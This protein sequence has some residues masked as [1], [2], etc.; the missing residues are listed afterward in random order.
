MTGRPVVTLAC[1]AFLLAACAENGAGEPG[2]G[3]GVTP[4]TPAD[5]SAGATASQ[6]PEVQAVVDAAVADL[7]RR[8]GAG[9]EPI[10]VLLARRETFPDGA[11][12]C[13]K[14]GRS[15]TQAL[16]DG[17]RVV[18][19]RGDHAWLYT[20]GPDGSPRMCTSTAWDG[21]TPFASPAAPTD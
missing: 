21:G 14:P 10:Q 1:C 6:E 4:P 2:S 16:V 12:G 3:S 15:Y 13:P 8:T 18:L 7:E 5:S 19:A 9:G 17:Y 11:L 20:A